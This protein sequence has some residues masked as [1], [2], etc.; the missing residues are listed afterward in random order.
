VNIGPQLNTSPVRPMVVADPS[1]LSYFAQANSARFSVR[2]VPG[3]LSGL[4]ADQ[5]AVEAANVGTA[6]GAGTASFLQ[7]LFG[8]K[9]NVGGSTPPPTTAYANSPADDTYLGL[10]KPVVIIGGVGLVAFI[11]WRVLK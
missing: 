11:A 5:P 2:H 7:T 3:A 4:G 8:G 10:P 6:V 9:V 1:K